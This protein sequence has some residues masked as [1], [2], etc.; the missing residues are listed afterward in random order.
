VRRLEAAVERPLILVAESDLNDPRLVKAPE[1]GGFGLH[2]QWSD[3][4]HHALHAW[5]TGE[6]HGYYADF[7]ALADLARAFEH[8]YV[9]AGRYSNFRR[10]R[11]GRSAS[12]VP[13]E[14]FLAY[15][16]NHD[17]VGNRAAGE[18]LSR[19]VGLGRLKL[20]AAAVL[21]SPFVPLL[22]QG[23]EWGAR[24]PFPFFSDHD[25][26]GL[27]RAVS[28]GRRREFA[29]FGWRPEDVPDP[30]DPRTFASARLDWDEPARPPH[31]T[32]LGWYRDLIRLRTTVP[33]LRDGKTVH[34]RFEEAQAWL[35]YDRGPLTIAYN[36]AP[37]P[38]RI[39]FSR[40][41]GRIVLASAD[42]ARTVPDGVMLP[43]D[44]VAIVVA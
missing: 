2:A 17:Q 1:C 37:E 21:T 42:E 8:G 18:R 5:L 10:R 39:P 26:P 35:C 38:R 33:G 6:R 28:E 36:F 23:E 30:Q 29:A 27:A 44:S 3:D 15:A 34:P 20:A 19:L 32:L 25:D 11:H 12:G 43:A 9:Y 16:Q 7:G 40:T 22:F 14:R 31:A 24:T 4:F 41:P 13:A